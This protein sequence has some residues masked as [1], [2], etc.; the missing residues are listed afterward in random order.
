MSY[1]AKMEKPKPSCKKHRHATVTQRGRLV[2]DLIKTRLGT[3]LSYKKILICKKK[4]K[5]DYTVVSNIF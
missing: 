5:K 4:K 2:L 1:F 3:N